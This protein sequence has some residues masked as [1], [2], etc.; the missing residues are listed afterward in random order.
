MKKVVKIAIGCA[1]FLSAVSL[2]GADNTTIDN[3]KFL[4]PTDVPFP[5]NNKPNQQRVELGKLLF[6]DVRLSTS[7]AISCATCHNPQKGWSDGIDRGMGHDNKQGGR[8]TPSILN[9]AYQMHQFW[10]GR[11]KTLEEQALGPIQADVEMNMNLD[12]LVSKI[13]TVKGYQDLFAIAYPNEGISKETIAKAIASFERTIVASDA[14]FDK[15]IKGDK[16]AIN[17][18]AK[19]GFELFKTKAGCTDCHSGFNFTDGSFHNIGVNDDAGR[20][21]VKQTEALKGAMI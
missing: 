7:N 8:N 15:Y 17:E 2:F 5:E 3:S 10:D 21:K 20:F 13:S 4:K 14:P 6:F 9:T 19:K 16:N 12:T 11:A 1:L 18:N